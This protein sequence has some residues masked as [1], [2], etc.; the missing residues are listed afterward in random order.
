MTDL[1]E[2]IIEAGVRA[3]RNS[4]AWPEVFSPGSAELLTRSALRAV[5][6]IVAEDLKAQALAIAHNWEVA[7]NRKSAYACSDAAR[8]LDSRLSEIMDGLK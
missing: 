2:K 1:S 4:K 6:P 5:L 3:M 7:G 8:V